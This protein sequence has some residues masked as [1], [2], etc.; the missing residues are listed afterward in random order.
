MPLYI[1]RRFS[2]APFLLLP[3]LT[4]Q[5]PWFSPQATGLLVMDEPDV[6]PE[7]SLP[8]PP[9]PIPDND[10]INITPQN[11]GSSSHPNFEENH[12]VVHVN[13]YLSED[14]DKRIRFSSED[15][16]E[17]IL[18]LSPAAFL[19]MTEENGSIHRVISNED[20]RKAWEAYIE[21]VPKE[22]TYEKNLYPLLVNL[23]DTATN[24]VY[25]EDRPFFFDGSVK[26]VQGSYAS[27]KPDIPSLLSEFGFPTDA[28]TMKKVK[29]YWPMIQSWLEVKHYAGI[30]L[31]YGPLAGR[32]FCSSRPTPLKNPT[33]KPT[34][35]PGKKNKMAANSPSKVSVLSEATTQ[36]DGIGESVN[37]V[38]SMLQITTN[39]IDSPLTTPPRT[40]ARILKRN[41]E[42]L[43]SDLT[44]E[45]RDTEGGL[46]SDQDRKRIR[47]DI[48]AEAAIAFV[49]Q[50]PVLGSELSPSAEAKLSKTQ[51]QHHTLL[52]C[53]G[54]GLETLSSGL[55]R[56]HSISIVVDSFNVQVTY[57]D[58]SMIALSEPVNLKTDHGRNIFLAVVLH[59]S[60]FSSKK[61]GLIPVKGSDSQSQPESESESESVSVSESQSESG[62]KSRSESESQS[63]SQSES[64]SKSRS[65]SE[66][67]STSQSESESQST[68]QSES[69]SQ[70][71]DRTTFPTIYPLLS[72]QYLIE[73][74]HQIQ[75]STPMK[76]TLKSISD[77]CGAFPGCNAFYDCKLTLGNGA[78]LNLKE[79]LYRSHSVIGRGTTVI[80]AEHND[81]D[82]A[83]KIS[84]LSASRDAED[85]L[86]QQAHQQ[87]KDEHAW[88][89]NHLPAIICSETRPLV[90]MPQ[91]RLAEFLKRFSDI[92]QYDTRVL[93]ITVQEIL[94]PITDLTD[95]KE[96]A[97][98][99]LDTLQIHR[100]LVDHGRILHRDISP[101]NIM[102]CRADGRVYGV[103]NDF[104]LASKLPLGSN[105]K[106]E[107]TSLRRTGTI[108]Y[109]PFDIL[110]GTWTGG[111]TYHHDLEAFFYVIAVLCG[112][113][114]KKDGSTH[115]DKVPVGHRQ[116]NKWFQADITAVAADKTSWVR[117]PKVPYSTTPFF[118]MK[119]YNLIKRLRRRL[120]FGHRQKCDH[121]D[122]EDDR[123]E[124]FDQKCD[125]ED[126]EDDRPEPFDW[127]TL[128]G[129]V[130]YEEF[131]QAMLEELSDFV[132]ITSY[133]K[134][135]GLRREDFVLPP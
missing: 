135:E 115:L 103:L 131:K 43:A 84:F 121:E 27:R 20:F 29:F 71:R 130:T 53:A 72:D 30:S 17:L 4:I 63:T 120:R 132:L 133:E 74:Q 32:G 9:F 96:I 81:S 1:A 58:R 5:P 109:L 129:Q 19:E 104:D 67:Q 101:A 110:N 83:V 33:K 6:V 14:V 15:F 41:H 12:N 107:T 77:S 119:F 26:V 90:D 118:G 122:S 16:L 117:T 37:A 25:G 42:D 57:Y 7:D 48:N 86:I 51:L 66:P 11:I 62:S 94:Q 68:S 76:P 3:S 113:Y 75:H 22:E 46:V 35:T 79:T 60:A 111:P 87:A 8:C 34:A 47:M 126:S 23:I 24:I 78:V 40:S 88:A 114:Q 124:L 69:G 80:K 56:S 100:W 91:L 95:A 50:E 45:A 116:F 39:H 92:P 99:L 21:A 31:D 44:G 64:G 125:H 102:F 52:Q 28:K 105:S 128:G 70:S 55:L 36:E 54:Y 127:L 65:E 134:Y 61:L 2:S 18:D 59:L 38:A 10:D 13:R 93:R 73:L 49:P 98:V 112:D 123:P 108:P 97:Q 85:E 82:V 89:K 106:C